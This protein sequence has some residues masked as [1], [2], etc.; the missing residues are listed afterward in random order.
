MTKY[1]IDKEKYG[2]PWFTEWFR[3]TLGEKRMTVDQVAE[4][5][6]LNPSTVMQY[7]QG[8]RNP[9]LKNFLMVVDALGKEVKIV[10][11]EQNQ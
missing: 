1:Q 10:E 11:K 6:G 7:R 3:K 8:V 2:V 5:T 9:T 4:K